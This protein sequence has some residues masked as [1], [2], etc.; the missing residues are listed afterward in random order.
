LVELAIPQRVVLLGEQARAEVEFFGSALFL[1][2]SRAR[3]SWLPNWPGRPT[4]A[5]SDD[6]GD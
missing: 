5:R 2:R 1:G 4:R 6:D 3:P